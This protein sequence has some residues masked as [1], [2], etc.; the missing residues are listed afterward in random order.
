[1]PGRENA[2]AKGRLLCGELE[3]EKTTGGNDFRD[4]DAGYEEDALLL[5]WR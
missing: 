4:I 5:C 1:M 2:P 3:R